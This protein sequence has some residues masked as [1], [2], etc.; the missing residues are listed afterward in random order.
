MRRKKVRV[1][2]LNDE[3]DFLIQNWGQLLTKSEWIKLRDNM[4]K[5]Y[6]NKTD[7]QIEEMNDFNYKQS[8]KELEKELAVRSSNSKKKKPGCVYFIGCNE[9]GVKIG[10]ST[11]VKGRLKSLN[12]SSPYTLSLI[13]TIECSN[14]EQVE[15]WAHEYFAP[16]RMNSEWFDITEK[17]IK[18]WIGGLTRG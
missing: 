2:V 10:F 13:D 6:R 5:F 14:Y 7:E 3:E 1:F 16:R 18:D 9:T 12:I 8:M 4:N 15:K 11:N 17:E